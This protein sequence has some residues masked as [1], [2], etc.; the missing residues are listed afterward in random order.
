[1]VQSCLEEALNLSTD[2]VV[3]I[4]EL[5]MQNEN[6]IVWQI[7]KLNDRNKLEVCTI[8]CDDQN[9]RYWRL[10]KIHI[11]PECSHCTR[12]E[13][14]WRG[15]RGNHCRKRT[16]EEGANPIDLQQKAALTAITEA[17]KALS[18]MDAKTT[19]AIAAT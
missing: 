7:Q 8:A 15:R 1:M 3:I 9:S 18:T 13:L 14:E 19:I 11:G 17:K 5:D 16:L 4:E 10:F 2:R 12:V 6:L